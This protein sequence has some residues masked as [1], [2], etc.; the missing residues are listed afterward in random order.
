MGLEVRGLVGHQ[1]IGGG[2]RLVESVAGELFHQVEH[3]RGHV[4]ADLV[5]ARAGDEDRAL[6]GHFLGLLLA[7][8][9]SQ[10]VGGAQ[11][12]AAD[13]LRDLHHLLLVDH[14]SVGRTEDRLHSRIQVLGTLAMLAFAEFR[15]Q[16]HRSGPVQRDQRDQVVQPVRAGPLQQVAHAARFELEHRGRVGAP[17]HFEGRRIVQWNRLQRQRGVRVQRPHVA[18]R[19]I[20]DRQRRQAEKVELDQADR[21]HVVLVELADRG[22]GALGAVQRA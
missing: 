20:Q 21:L 7:H 19:Q 6:L 17:E 15:N 18:Q 11:R 8:G 12:V 22:L 16:L 5:G 9:P 3:L 1:R 14:D 13:H 10:Q 4:L 2:V